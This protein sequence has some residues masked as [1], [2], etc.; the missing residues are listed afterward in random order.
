MIL[1]FCVGDRSFAINTTRRPTSVARP[2][3]NSTLVLTFA[4]KRMDDVWNL[5]MTGAEI[6][7]TNASGSIV[8]Q[9]ISAAEVLVLNC[10]SVALTK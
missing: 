5:N 2:M 1:H 9:S 7:V 3:G 10:P 8:H 6:I 4:A